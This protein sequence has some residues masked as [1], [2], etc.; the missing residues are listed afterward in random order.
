LTSLT[1]AFPLFPLRVDAVRPPF[2]LGIDDEDTNDDDDGGVDSE[3]IKA[4]SLFGEKGS[5]GFFVV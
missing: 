4:R 5:K 2:L 1:V 3:T